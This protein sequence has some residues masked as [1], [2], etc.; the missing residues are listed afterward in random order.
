MKYD[1]CGGIRM[2]AVLGKVSNIAEHQG[3]A[4]HNDLPM[5]LATIKENQMCCWG[6]EEIETMCLVGGTVTQR[7][8]RKLHGS[9]SEDLK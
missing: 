2:P 9:C 5:R 1:Q 4:H 3:N 7:H 6:C 8:Y